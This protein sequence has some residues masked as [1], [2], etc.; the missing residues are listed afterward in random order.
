MGTQVPYISHTS[1]TFACSMSSMGMIWD[2][3]CSIFRTFPISADIT[4]SSPID[5]PYEYFIKALKIKSHR[6]SI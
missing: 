4:F 2:V 3:H 1:N 6:V 5:A